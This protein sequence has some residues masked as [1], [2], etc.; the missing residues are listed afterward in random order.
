MPSLQHCVRAR[1]G[2]G[3]VCAA[4]VLSALPRRTGA[5]PSARLHGPG[6]P[7][8]FTRRCFRKC[9]PAFLC[10][11]PGG[12]CFSESALCVGTRACAY[13]STSLVRTGCA[14]ARGSREALRLP[15]LQPAVPAGHTG[16]RVLALLPRRRGGGR[17]PALHSLGAAPSQPRWARRCSRRAETPRSGPGRCSRRAETPAAAPGA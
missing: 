16:L 13:G 3:A 14:S 9:C 5:R 15:V 12:P 11:S 10:A 2:P 4:S 7:G 8:C 1:G 6:A 17:V